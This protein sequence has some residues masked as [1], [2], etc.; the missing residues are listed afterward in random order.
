MKK[1]ENFKLLTND[2]DGGGIFC[3]MPFDVL[4]AKQKQKFKLQYSSDINEELQ[5][6]KTI[7]PVGFSMIACISNPKERKKKNGLFIDYYNEII[8]FIFLLIKKNGG[9]SPIF[10][11]KRDNGWIYCSI[12]DIHDAFEIAQMQ[13]GGIF[14]RFFLEGTSID[15]HET[16]IIENNKKNP[17]F[18]GKL[19]YHT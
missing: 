17:Q 11:N 13:Y 18:V 7:F 4:D 3:Y 5:K 12:S 9:I 1:E 14:T 2:M 10:S 6:L 19:V 15:D 8:Q 16:V